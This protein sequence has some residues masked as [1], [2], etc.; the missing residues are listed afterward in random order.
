MEEQIM[1][2]VANQI[3]I[4]K[5]MGHD[6]TDIDCLDMLEKAGRA[7]QIGDIRTWGNKDYIKTPKGWRP[8]PVGFKPSAKGEKKEGPEFSV[9]KEGKLRPGTAVISGREEAGKMKYYI[10]LSH[11]RIDQYGNREMSSEANALQTRSSK[12]KEEAK[13]LVKKFTDKWNRVLADEGEKK[14]TSGK[15]KRVT[16][17][18]LP[19]DGLKVMDALQTSRSEYDDPS[20]VTV[21]RSPKNNWILYYD[22][23]DTGTIIGGDVL[24]ENTVKELGWEHHDK[25]PSS[26]KIEQKTFHVKD[27]KIRASMYDKQSR[28]SKLMKFAKENGLE[29]EWE[30]SKD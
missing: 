26:V 8:V 12:S 11:M 24:R 5:A 29:I 6:I 25:T 9:E 18:N 21:E 22:G 13:E 3:A 14:E 17:E 1:R 23:K 2:G 7:A 19:H 30:E 28:I 16:M 27:G 20:K 4:Q 10:N 15:K